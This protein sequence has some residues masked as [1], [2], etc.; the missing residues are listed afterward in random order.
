MTIDEQGTARVWEPE[1]GV[2]HPRLGRRVERRGAGHRAPTAAVVAVNSRDQTIRLWDV[3]GAKPGVRSL[4]RVCE[5]ACGLTLQGNASSR[6]APMGFPDLG[7]SDRRGAHSPFGDSVFKESRFFGRDGGLLATSDALGM[8]RMWDAATGDPMTPE[9]EHLDDARF[10]SYDPEAHKLTTSTRL[11]D[12]R[13]GP[14]SLQREIEHLERLAQIGSGRRID[15]TGGE[16]ALSLAAFEQT[17][18][19]LGTAAGSEQPVGLIAGSTAEL[20]LES[21]ATDA[22]I[23]RDKSPLSAVYH[24]NALI[25]SGKMA[26]PAPGTRGIDVSAGPVR[27][28]RC[29]FPRRTSNRAWPRWPRSIRRGGCSPL[30]Q[31]RGA[32]AG[33]G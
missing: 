26:V 10:E 31:Q 21:L 3:G 1:S 16:A 14:R 4:R 9:L 23:Y 24:L 7:C 13:V 30:D 32:Q 20:A 19:A 29:R 25:D 11:A 8:L 5:R 27:R 28:S 15:P 17:W 18:K 12:V 2:S 6:S 22:G 33:S